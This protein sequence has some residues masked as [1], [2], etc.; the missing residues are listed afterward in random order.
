M[1][2]AF[3][4]HSLTVRWYCRISLSAWVPGLHLL[5]SPLVGGL[6]YLLPGTS[7]ASCAEKYI[8]YIN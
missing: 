8:T 2:A 4:M 5:P 1:N 6:K 7:G 3:E